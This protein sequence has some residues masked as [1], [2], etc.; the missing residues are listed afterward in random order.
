MADI[1][2][3]IRLLELAITELKDCREVRSPK[4]HGDSGARSVVCA[5]FVT[6]E[7][8]STM[9]GFTRKAIESKIYRGDWLEGLH[10]VRR[11]GRVLID[12]QSYER[13]AEGR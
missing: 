5:R 8:A 2:A 1:S 7:L 4:A 6:I 13:W 10:W 11:D 9:T 3:A 12:M